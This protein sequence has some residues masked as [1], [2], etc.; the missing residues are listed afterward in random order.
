[1][2]N[3]MWDHFYV[4]TIAMVKSAEF[5]KAVFIKKNL[6]QRNGSAGKG[7]IHNQNENKYHCVPSLERESEK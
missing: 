4:K 1:M 5:Q 6:N 3:Q 2:S 7:F